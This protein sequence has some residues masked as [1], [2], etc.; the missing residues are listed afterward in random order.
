M[1]DTVSY[2]VRS[3]LLT[4]RDEQEYISNIL[5]VHICDSATDDKEQQLSILNK[6]PHF[7]CLYL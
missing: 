5:F 7:V 6:R 4:R 3:F 1:Q 2:T